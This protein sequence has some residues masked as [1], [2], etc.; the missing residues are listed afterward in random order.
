MRQKNNNFIVSQK[1]SVL[2]GRGTCSGGLPGLLGK[3]RGLQ[4]RGPS[5]RPEN[6]EKVPDI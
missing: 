4:A 2:Q 3:N 6:N 1:L 5:G